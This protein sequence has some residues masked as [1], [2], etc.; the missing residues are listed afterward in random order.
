MATTANTPTKKPAG[1][2]PITR[3]RAGLTPEAVLDAILERLL[4]FST[5]AFADVKEA[6]VLDGVTSIAD[7]LAMTEQ[8]VHGLR[9]KKPGEDPLLAPSVTCRH[10]TIW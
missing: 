9:H 3:I 7:V 4:R 6:L 8:D 5:Q 10:E 1:S 2:P